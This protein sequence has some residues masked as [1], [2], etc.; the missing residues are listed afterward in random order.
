MARPMLAPEPPHVLGC[1]RCKNPLVAIDVGAG[2]VV[3]ACLACKALFVP[4][5]GWVRAFSAR[6]VVGD[7]EARIGVAP[8]A[9]L[10]LLASCPVCARQM[11]R[12]RFAATSEVVIDACGAGHGVWLASGVLGRAVDYAAHKERIGANAAVREAD[13]AWLR[14]NNVDPRRHAIE[15][16]E[17]YV[18]AASAARLSKYAK[19]GGA[20]IALVILV[21][22]FF[23]MM[24]HSTHRPSTRSSGARVQAA[25]TQGAADL[26]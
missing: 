13:A 1:V 22:L 26:Q 17:A 7:L 25:G 19:G 14:A 11:D 21:R 24:D 5:R 6:D 20:G 4:P 10:G 18:R 2:S 3:H 16:E 23:F 8:R 9:E 15:T 12:T